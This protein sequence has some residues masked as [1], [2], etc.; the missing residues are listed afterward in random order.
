MAIRI[1]TNIDALIGQNNLEKNNFN[2]S[3]TL[4]RL[5]TGL[6]VNRSADDPSGMAVGTKHETSIRGTRKALDNVHYGMDYLETA[7]GALCEI[8][9]MVQRIRELVIKAANDT[10]TLSDREK[11]QYEIDELLKNI[12]QTAITTEYNTIKPLQIDPFR[13]KELTTIP[14]PCDISFVIDTSASMGPYIMNVANNLTQFVNA[15]VGQ[16]V[17]PSISIT[18]TSN[19]GAG[20]WGDN[21]DATYTVLPYTTDTA[22]VVAQLNTIAAM[23]VG[24]LVDPYNALLEIS[25]IN[26]VGG[27]PIVTDTAGQAGR[28]PDYLPRQ[29]GTVPYFQIV[30]T[31]VAPEI[32]VGSYTGYPIPADPAR[33]ADVANA[34]ATGSG[35]GVASMSITVY[36]VVPP[37]RFVNY[38]D[39]TMATGGAL[40]NINSP[41]FGNDL[42]SIANNIAAITLN[43]P[44][45][46]WVD[47]ES[48]K[49][50]TGCTEGDILSFGKPH[51]THD[52]LGLVKIDVVHERNS[53]FYCLTESD[54]QS[55]QDRGMRSS[56]IN[57]LKSMQDVQYTDQSSF[58]AALNGLA[59]SPTDDEKAIIKL[60]ADA[61]DFDK[62]LQQVDTALERLA[63]MRA[64]YGAIYNRFESRMRRLNIYDENLSAARSR[65]MDTDF[66]KETANLT[67]N[68]ILV[69]AGTAIL[70]Q[71]N[72]E[73]TSALRLLQP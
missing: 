45:K 4:E 25:G 40:Y 59:S 70:A 41:T 56:L 51:I 46:L 43:A 55:L 12:D 72:V 26:D 47:P 38:D 42:L 11:I 19:N 34:L 39:I 15:L 36:A 1:N 60:Y 23:V 48:Q 22:T 29:G 64:K 31:D 16:N 33:E 18:S 24:A 6:R 54:I 30:L 28:D 50:Q 66:A 53:T 68:Q 44:G 73:P 27:M 37:A 71:A 57:E 58:D 5:S 3:K 20:P 61:E 21:M 65:L 67:K 2:L 62:Y 35:P 32:Q 69:Q 63:T 49:I 7:E 8:T 10:H 17:K 14:A 9:N 13:L 52:A